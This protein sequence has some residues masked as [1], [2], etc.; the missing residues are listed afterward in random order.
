MFKFS[1]LSKVL[2][3]YVPA[4]DQT[5][6][7]A[8]LTDVNRKKN[9]FATIIPNDRHRPILKTPG[10]LGRT[11][12]INAMYVDAY[13]RRNGFIVTHTP[14]TG[15][16]TDLWK[17]VYDYDITTIVTLNGV[18]FHEDSCAEYWPTGAVTRNCE[19]FL[20]KPVGNVERDHMTIRS[21]EL[22][23][24]LNPSARARVVRQF[25]LESWTMYDKVPWLREGFLE[26]IDAVDEAQRHSAFPGSPVLVHCMDG[27]SQSGLYCACAV[28]CEKMRANGQVDVFH[29]IKRMKKRRPHFVNSLVCGV[30]MRRQY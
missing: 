10:G 20:V 4:L 25:R 27:A 30:S 1:F 11:D 8:A 17:L 22:T 2:E 3:E 16:T 19:P 28:L 12:Y 24:S 26:L 29:T 15:T 7:I 5:Q 9:R 23:C 21:A 6:T 13:A 18:D 14:L